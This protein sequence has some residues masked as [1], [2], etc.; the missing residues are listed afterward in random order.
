MKVTKSTK[1]TRGHLKLD[2]IIMQ[3]IETGEELTISL[4]GQQKMKA[5]DLQRAVEFTSN[6][7]PI[8]KKYKAGE[9][10]KYVLAAPPDAVCT[11]TTKEEWLE[12]FMFPGTSLLGYQN[13]DDSLSFLFE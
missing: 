4:N 9:N 11:P 6:G 10:K 1:F 13:D 12:D 7:A 5:E 8:Q 3:S 2:Q